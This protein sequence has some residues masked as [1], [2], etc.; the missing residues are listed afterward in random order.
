MTTKY[1]A[2]YNGSLV[3]KR[4]SNIG[5]KI[6]THAIVAWGH[7]KNP[8]VVAWASRIDLAQTQA[9]QYGRR[10]CQTAIVP[11]EI[12]PPRVKIRDQAHY[13]SLVEAGIE[14]IRF[15]K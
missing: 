12:V 8:H 5:N 11:A 4:T 14:P 3:G 9:R 1:I 15:E 6:Y 13:D 10:G 7:G 2:H